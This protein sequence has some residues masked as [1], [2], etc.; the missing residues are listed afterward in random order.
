MNRQLKEKLFSKLKKY[1]AARNEI[2]SVYIFGSFA[3]HRERKDSDIDIALF[4]NQKEIKNPLRYRIEISTEL[5]DLI[6]KKVEVVVLNFANLLI[7]A[8]V[9][10]KGILLYERNPDQRALFQA[11]TM[12][13]YYD[14]KK[15]FQFHA[16]HLKNKIKEVG[17]G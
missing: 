15:Y 9:F 2:I 5:M 4:V 8:Q 14:Y 7:R 13:L 16:K 6:K 1:F 17:L 12:G 3:E 11:Q 10:E